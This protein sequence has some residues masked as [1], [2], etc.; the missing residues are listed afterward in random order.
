MSEARRE[1]VFGEGVISSNVIPAKDGIYFFTTESTEENKR[2]I[3]EVLDLR[4]E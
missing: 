3:Y 4:C 1:R 2:F